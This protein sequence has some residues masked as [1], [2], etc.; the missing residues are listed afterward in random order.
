VARAATEALSALLALLAKSANEAVTVIL[1]GKPNVTLTSLPTFVTAVS[2]SFVVPMICK[3]S[4][5]KSTF[6][7]PVSPSTVK[8]DATPVN[9]EPSP[10]NEPLIVPP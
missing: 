10:T 3:S 8:V 4:V 6:C 7:V 2:I 1:L 9:P 5:C